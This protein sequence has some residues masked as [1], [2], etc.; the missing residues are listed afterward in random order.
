VTPEPNEPV[1]AVDEAPPGGPPGD[2]APPAEP[3]PRSSTAR[4]I[5]EAVIVIVVAVLVAVLLRAFVV[6]TF[7]IPS[8]SATV[9]SSTS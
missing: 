1:L 7:Y 3:E 9:F 8:G 4:W 2:E 5:R 6:Q